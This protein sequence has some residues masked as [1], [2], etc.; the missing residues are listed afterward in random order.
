M[1]YCCFTCLIWQPVISPALM[2]TDVYT[3]RYLYFLFTLFG[4]LVSHELCITLCYILP[5]SSDTELRH[6]Q[7]LICLQF[8]HGF[9]DFFPCVVFYV[10]YTILLVYYSEAMIILHRRDLYK[11][12][13]SEPTRVAFTL[14]SNTR[15]WYPR[16]KLGETSNRTQGF[17][18]DREVIQKELYN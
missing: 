9:H 10:Y 15:V 4:F 1:Y 11:V 2:A 5:R 17:V 16:S 8:T 14:M 13:T 3:Y 7:C 12:P 18:N 6:V